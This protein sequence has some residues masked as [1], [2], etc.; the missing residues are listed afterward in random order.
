MVWHTTCRVSKSKNSGPD[1]GEA[2]VE[3]RYALVDKRI[4]HIVIAMT[5]ISVAYY[6][7]LIFHCE[8]HMK[9]E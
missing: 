4:P 1:A 7:K 6:F 5:N 8:E 2:I 3:G 9:I